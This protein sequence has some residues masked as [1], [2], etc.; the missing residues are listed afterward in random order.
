MIINI[1]QFVT[2]FVFLSVILQQLVGMVQE[3]Q[4]N[5]WSLMG[6]FSVE[7]LLRNKYFQSVL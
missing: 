7:M 4:R 2:I 5:A 6:L 1:V 3:R